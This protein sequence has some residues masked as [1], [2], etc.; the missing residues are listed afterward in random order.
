MNNFK[1]YILEKLKLGKDTKVAENP[2]NTHNY[3]E[4][5]LNEQI[6]SIDQ[7]KK[8]LENYFTKDL[9]NVSYIH[10]QIKFVDGYTENEY[11]CEP[12]FRLNFKN[13]DKLNIGLYKNKFYIFLLRMKM[14]VRSP[15]SVYSASSVIGSDD[16]YPLANKMNL[17]DWIYKIK[18]NYINQIEEGYDINI[19]QK[20]GVIT[21]DEI[22]DVYNK[23]YSK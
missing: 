12:Y 14:N 3:N 8:I 10:K 5:I 15:R 21:D 19:L 6:K 16:T 4:S 22:Q 1:T 9:L 11:Y 20:F 23:K 2:N 13:G 7:L 17:L 18:D